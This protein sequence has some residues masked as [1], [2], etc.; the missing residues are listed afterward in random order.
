MRPAPTVGAITAAIVVLLI[1]AALG[2]AFA[3]LAGE[4]DEPPT[5]A[6]TLRT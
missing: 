4:D 5:P 6:V 2:I 1:A 3:A